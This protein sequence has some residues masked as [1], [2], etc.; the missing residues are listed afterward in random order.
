[1]SESE[2]SVVE[3]RT[4]RPIKT[5][6]RFMLII[7]AAVIFTLF[8]AAAMLKPDSKGWG[9]HRQLGLPPCSFMFFC[10]VPCPTCGFTTTWSHLMNGDVPSAIRTNFAAVLL[11]LL[12]AASG[13]WMLI[14][15]CLGRWFLLLPSVY[16]W[17]AIV[18]PI[19]IVTFV[20]W[21]SRIFVVPN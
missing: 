17:A 9:T 6:D 5:G 14:S 13:S 16:M 8:A 4:D 11:W 1:M 3:S 19:I 2:T 15:G 10:G 12:A 21:I 18:A 7:G 20:I